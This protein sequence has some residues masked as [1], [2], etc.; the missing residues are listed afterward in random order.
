MTKKKFLDEIKSRLKGLPQSDIDKSLDYYSEMIEDRIED[1][2]SE[3]EAVADLGTVDEIVAQIL[4]DIPLPKIVKEK[5][6][7]KRALAAWEIVLLVLGFPLWF[8]VLMV[9]LSVFL[10]VYIVLWSVVITLYATD[11]VIAFGGVACAGAGILFMTMAK[12]VPGIF[13]LGMGLIFVGISVL[14][15]FLF[16]FVTVGIVKLS[17]LIVLGVKSIFVRKEKA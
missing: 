1:G 9:V 10:A 15:F 13:M 7:P 3:E 2:M 8:S 5:V 6:S 16:N 17:R 11:F 4:N 12:P 14:L